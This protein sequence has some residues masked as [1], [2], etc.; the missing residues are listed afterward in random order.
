MTDERELRTSQTTGVRIDALLSTIL[1]SELLTPSDELWLISPWVSDVDA[2]DNT[3]GAFDT[4]FSDPSNK[5]YLLSEVLGLLTLSGTRLGV[6][7]RPDSHNEI[8]L[9]RLE[10]CADSVNLKVIR[11]RTIHEKTFCGMDWQ[12]TGSMNFTYRGININ[13]ELMKYRVDAQV[14][15]GTRVEF[16]H[17]F[18]GEW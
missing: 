5:I 4:A 11:D 3:G 14:A 10:R 9:A 12:L 1:V 6:V 17:R 16:A 18:G 15:A 2:I 8:F 7:T 13:D